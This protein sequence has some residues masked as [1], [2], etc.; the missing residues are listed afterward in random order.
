MSVARRARSPASSAIH[1]SPWAARETSEPPA[2]SVTRIAVARSVT[3]P[4]TLSTAVPRCALRSAA[5]RSSSSSV[6]STPS[7]PASFIRSAATP[8]WSPADAPPKR[9]SR[10]PE[11]CCQAA[12]SE[13]ASSGSA[14]SF[15]A[16]A[17]STSAS[18]LAPNAVAVATGLGCSRT[19][20]S[21]I[22]PSVPYEP[23]NSLP[24]S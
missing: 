23:V 2:R 15:M 21:R 17:A 20:T 14:A 10:R 16:A 6:V 9:A 24:R 11:P 3:R 19:V 12:S 4:E 8:A 13:S 18:S 22:S 1:D 5:Q 7:R